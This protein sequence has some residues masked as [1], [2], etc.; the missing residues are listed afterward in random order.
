MRRRALGETLVPLQKVSL[1]MRA[2]TT[3]ELRERLLSLDTASMRTLSEKAG[4]SLRG[5]WKIRA[6][7]T[8]TAS[9]RV[10]IQV[11]AFMPRRRKVAV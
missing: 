11:R 6:G 5:L 8:L 3:S 2:M 10:K 7:S 9:E 4:V 1:M